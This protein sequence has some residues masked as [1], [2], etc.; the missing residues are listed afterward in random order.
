MAGTK[1]P[2]L[3]GPRACSQW[4][5]AM[6]GE[7]DPEVLASYGRLPKRKYPNLDPDGLLDQANSVNR[8]YLLNR[9]WTRSMIRRFLG[10]PDRTIPL[11]INHSRPECRYEMR[12]V[13]EAESRAD[14][15]AE[16]SALAPKRKRVGR[17]RKPRCEI[18]AEATALLGG[19]SQRDRRIVSMLYLGKKQRLV[20]ARQRTS[21]Q[22]VS[23]VWTRFRS[24]VNS[25]TRP[26]AQTG[27]NQDITAR[28]W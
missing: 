27:K 25:Q 17:P 5:R 1:T 18:P 16:L 19:L 2:V 9:G 28:R 12:R 15:C 23:L 14:F 10:A 21:Q 22:T 8:A 26:M 24:A 3:H 13:F 20:A 11:R 7:F 6:N 4:G